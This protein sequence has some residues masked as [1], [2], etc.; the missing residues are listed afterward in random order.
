MPFATWQRQAQVSVAFRCSSVNR[1][2]NG[3][4]GACLVCLLMALPTAHARSKRFVCRIVGESDCCCCCC[5][6]TPV[7]SPLVFVTQCGGSATTRSTCIAYSS[8]Y[9]SRR[10]RIGN[11]SAPCVDKSGTSERHRQRPTMIADQNRYRYVVFVFILV[12]ICVELRV[13]LVVSLPWRALL[14]ASPLWV[15]R[16]VACIVVVT[17]SRQKHR[18]HSSSTL[19]KGQR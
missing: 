14:A 3:S 10:S 6:C 18:N 4:V 9:S 12:L 8:T 1:S 7:A 16:P 17:H 2:I 11:S 13:F 19:S 5:C 15:W